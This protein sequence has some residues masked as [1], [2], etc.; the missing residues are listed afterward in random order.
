MT[1]EIIL[2]TEISIKEVISTQKSNIGSVVVDTELHTIVFYVRGVSFKEIES[3]Y[4]ENVVVD[5]GPNIFAGG[6]I[7]IP[8]GW[9]VTFKN[10]ETIK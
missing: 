6:S 9:S 4:F 10:E 3:A 7:F 8:Y 2:K 5:G 1:K